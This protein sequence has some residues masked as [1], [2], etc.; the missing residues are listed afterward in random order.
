MDG[1]RTV[2]AL[3]RHVEKEGYF[4][5]SDEPGP[6]VL[7]AHPRVARISVESGGYNAVRTPMDLPVAQKLIRALEGIRGPLVLLPTMGGSLPLAVIEEI[8][9]AP[10]I[11]VPTVNSDNNQH[12]KNENLRLGNLWTGIE[13]MAALFVME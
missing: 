9:G 3:I 13:T 1:A 10:T 11:T 12:A 5:T 2:S 6:E 8:V 4:V 7:L